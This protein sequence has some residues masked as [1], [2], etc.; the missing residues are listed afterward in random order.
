MSDLN[1]NNTQDIKVSDNVESESI[2][3][4]LN[5]D[6][7]SFFSDEFEK[8]QQALH[9]STNTPVHNETRIHNNRVLDSQ[10]QPATLDINDKISA[11]LANKAHKDKENNKVAKNSKTNS[12]TKSLVMIGLIA[13]LLMSATVAAAIVIL[14]ITGKTDIMSVFSG[15]TLTEEVSPVPND[16]AVIIAENDVDNESTTTTTT[17]DIEVEST[18]AQ[19]ADPSLNNATQADD[20][21]QPAQVPN[22]AENQNT[23]QNMVQNTDKNTQMSLEEF[24]QESEVTLYRD[25]SQ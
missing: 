18:P 13:A 4:D 6:E 10:D 22:A 16:E 20:Q 2:Y 14:N 9:A 5:E 24:M 17:N 25:T 23:T 7:L 19:P 21:P 12:D 15:D 3:R 1:K 8:E 11:H